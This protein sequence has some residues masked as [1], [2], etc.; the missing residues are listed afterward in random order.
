MYKEFIQENYDIIN[1]LIDGISMGIWITDEKGV[2]LIINQTCVETGGYPKEEII[3][4]TTEELLE[5]GYILHESSVLNAI[6][7]GEKASIVQGIGIGGNILA[8]SVPLYT[9]GKI[10]IVVC[11]E[12]NITDVVKLQNLLASQKKEQLLLRSE[13]DSIKEKMR[14]ERTI[15]DEMIAESQYMLHIMQI[16]SDIGPMD[17]TVIISGESGVGKEMVANRIVQQSKRA[18]G[19]FVTVNCSAIPETLMESE[20]FGY[21]KGAFTGADV[22]GKIGLFEQ[23]DKGT[24]F[25]DEIGEVPIQMQGKLLRVIQ[26][27]VIRRIGAEEEK[28]IDVRIIAATNRNLKNEMLEGN[29]RQ[30][31]YYRL[32]VFPI[33]IPPL[34]ERKEDIA[35]LARHFL[36][37]INERYRMNKSITQGAIVELEKYDWPGNV[38]ELGNIIERLALNGHS[39]VISTMQVSRFLTAETS[40]TGEEKKGKLWNGNLGDLV[41]EYEKH[42]LMDV[43]EDSSSATQ[44]AR[45]LGIDKST[46]LRKMKKYNISQTKMWKVRK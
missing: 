7:T 17:S 13:L 29:F 25:L 24:I 8:T 5:S 42:I 27:G 23:A 4:K 1:E 28:K 38:R 45:K 3:G 40:V 35:P 44:A 14:M 2:V 31:L 16:A 46:M 10:D 18:D 37:K 36:N 20:F 39:D 22:R 41:G 33:E 11:A 43:L 12:K 9:N 19:P 6:R 30:D 32:N 15:E 21:E 26:E 34:R